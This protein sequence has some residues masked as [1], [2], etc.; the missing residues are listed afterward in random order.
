ME[1]QQL[2]WQEMFDWLVAHPSGDATPSSIKSYL[3]GQSWE[4]VN[5]YYQK[6]TAEVQADLA[7]VR[8]K[9][10]A[11]PETVKA[12]QDAVAAVAARDRAYQELGWSKLFNTVVNGG[13]LITDCHANRIELAGLFDSIRDT[14][15]MSPQWLQKILQEQPQLLRRLAVTKY[16]TPQE[17]KQ[18]SQETD[19][20]TKQTLLSVCQR[21]NYSF[22]LANQNA[23]LQFFPDGCNSFQLEQAIQNGQLHLHGA[24]W[25][26][27]EQ[28]T[29]D[30]VRQHNI[31]WANKSLAEV[32][33]GSAQERAERDAIFSRITPEPTRPTGIVP[34]P[35][36][37]TKE[38][39]MNASRETIALWRTRYSLE[40]LNARLQGL[41]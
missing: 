27:I 7:I 29:K 35:E 28:H 2:G 14:G 38:K 17:T 8:R 41:A 21:Y 40:S 5:A 20:A 34:L 3:T 37:I 26:E 22:S 4:F 15:G 33:A 10:D 19:E 32:K 31:R 1:T 25:A 24:D 12:R 39:I 6:R 36:V 11:D 16:E 18:R 30:L 13:Y 23:V 9:L